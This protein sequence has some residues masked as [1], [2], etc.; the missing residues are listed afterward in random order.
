M[1]GKPA[2]PPAG[3]KRAL[4]HGAQ[5]VALVTARASEIV[6]ALVDALPAFAECDRPAVTRLAETYVRIERAYRWLDEQGL[7]DDAGQVPPVIERLD[8][9]ETLAL[10]LED[11]L[12]MNPAAR[13]KLGLDLVR[14]EALAVELR[15]MS[16]QGEKARERLRQI[17]GEGDA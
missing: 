3:N 7:I 2:P 9:W 4:K 11:R 15:R 8:R 1:A 5:S 12:G 6:P 14:G 16:E 10:G 13:A 17:R